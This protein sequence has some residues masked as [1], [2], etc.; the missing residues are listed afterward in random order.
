MSADDATVKSNLEIDKTLSPLS[1]RLA[2]EIK[3][4]PK[5]CDR[6]AIAHI[7]EPHLRSA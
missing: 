2:D 3:A 4:L 7:L 6:E 5:F 1:L